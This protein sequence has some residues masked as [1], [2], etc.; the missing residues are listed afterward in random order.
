MGIFYNDPILHGDK[1]LLMADGFRFSLHHIA[2]IY[3]VGKQFIDNAGLPRAAANQPLMDDHACICLILG[4]SRHS[5]FI[6]I[7]YNLT[8]RNSVHCPLKYLPDN[9]R[10]VGI[11]HQLVAVL[12]VFKVAIGRA[13]PHKLS[14]LHSLPL[15]GTHFSADIGGI[16]LVH[17]A[18]ISATHDLLVRHNYSAND[19]AARYTRIWKRFKV[20]AVQQGEEMFSADLADRYLSETYHFPQEYDV[21]GAFPSEVVNEI[22]AIRSLKACYL[23]G[24][25]APFLKPKR[26]YVSVHFPVIYSSYRANR[27]GYSGLCAEWQA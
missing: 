18:V 25:I 11:D 26:E 24:S 23:Y 17:H 3:L 20:Y 2:H 27:S 13:A 14:L 22:R 10:G 15:L 4:R 6:E 5:A 1:L 9:R 8:E 21:L 7:S 16:S 19:I 12:G